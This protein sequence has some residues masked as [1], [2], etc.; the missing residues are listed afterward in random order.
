M[1]WY[2]ATVPLTVRLPGLETVHEVIV[3]FRFEAA[4]PDQAE[5]IAGTLT[6]PL[7]HATGVVP[8][9][10]FSLRESRLPG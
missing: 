7:T 1:S 5:R 2:L 6:E 9:R 3:T 8:A 4:D 10:A